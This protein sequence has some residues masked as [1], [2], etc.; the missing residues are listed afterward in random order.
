MNHINQNMK[1]LQ[2][3]TPPVTLIPETWFLRGE[4][5]ITSQK[6]L[7]QLA[8]F[9][10]DEPFRVQMDQESLVYEVQTYLPVKEGTP[11]GLNFG[12]TLIHPGKV[13]NEY[14]MTR[15]HF[16]ALADSAEF[17]WGV[18]G[19][20]V[21]I[22]MDENRHTRAEKMFPGSLHYIG[23]NTAHRVANTGSTPLIFGACWPSDAGHN[24]EAIDQHGF[25]ARLLEIEGVPC[26]I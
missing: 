4:G 9:F 25:S 21:L 15:G 17:Y 23:A 14:F 10:A 22:L 13:G 18:Q 6:R 16:H 1:H 2:I 19:D 11:G 26:L 5:I 24:Y 7:H 8:G 3:H 20:G 12:T